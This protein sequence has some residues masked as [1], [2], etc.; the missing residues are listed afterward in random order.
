MTVAPHPAELKLV[1]P[2]D[3]LELDLRPLQGLWTEVQYLTLTEQTNHLIEFTDGSI[4]V[5]P[6]PTDQHQVILL[7]LYEL[8]RTYLRA[9]HGKVLVAP[10]R[11]QIR[12]GKFREPDL[13]LV[14]RADDPR[15]QNR[16]W[17]G[18]DLVVEIVSPDDPERDTVEKRTDYAEAGIPEYWIVHPDDESITVLT[19]QDSG[20]R[21]H[22]VFRRGEQAHSRL[23]DGFVV[24]VDAVL[25][26]E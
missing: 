15:R 9:T 14:R 1:R 25:D 11:L 22:G 21:E 8:L 19:L 23:L 16:Y 20:Y 24:S 12:E 18:A 10:L 2:A 5:L 4:E 6:M 26:A 7:F 13:L 17:L 3:G